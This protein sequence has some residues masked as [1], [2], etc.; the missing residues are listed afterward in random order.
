MAALKR[1][2]KYLPLKFTK[3]DFGYEKNYLQFNHPVGKMCFWG[4]LTFH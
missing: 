3:Q 2:I 1:K 4:I